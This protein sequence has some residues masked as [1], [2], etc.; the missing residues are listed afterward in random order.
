MY[1]DRVGAVNWKI[2]SDRKVALVNAFPNNGN[3]KFG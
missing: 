2:S 3:M 1:C